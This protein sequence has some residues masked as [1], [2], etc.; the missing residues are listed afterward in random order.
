[1]N[2]EKSNQE[3][4]QDDSEIE[5]EEN[6][7]SAIYDEPFPMID[8][9]TPEARE[10]LYTTPP[11]R[12]KPRTDGPPP[13]SFEAT[14]RLADFSPVRSSVEDL[15]VLLVAR[16]DP[17]IQVTR[18]TLSPLRWVMCMA[19]PNDVREMRLLLLDHG[20]FESADDRK[21]WAEREKYD[22]DEP[23]IMYNFHRDDRVGW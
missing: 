17:N 7:E 18:G 6:P 9:S 2:R 14:K 16:A 13:D 4:M 10:R 3:H 19:R 12:K 1:M 11:P 23:A 8:V 21:R 5:E 15:R 22:M 20:A